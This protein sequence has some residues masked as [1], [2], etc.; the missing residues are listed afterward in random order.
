GQTQWPPEIDILEAPTNNVGQPHNTIRMGSQVKGLQTASR[1]FEFTHS[2]ADYDRQWQN[3]KPSRT[4]RDVWIEVGALW[5]ATNVCYFVDGLK[6]A[7]EN[8]NWADNNGVAANNAYAILNLAIGG[9][10]A[11]ASGIEDAKF[12]T[13]VE[14]DHVRIYRSP[15]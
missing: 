2:V 6:T 3:Y 13:Q 1:G 15:N 14:V 12:P 11:G 8:Y 9:S 5:T 4:L 7:C 10:W